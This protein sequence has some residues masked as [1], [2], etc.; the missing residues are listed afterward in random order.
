MVPQNRLDGV[1]SEQF[2]LKNS[3]NSVVLF[4]VLNY[5]VQTNSLLVTINISFHTFFYYRY[6]C[7]KIPRT[8]INAE[9]NCDSYELYIVILDSSFIFE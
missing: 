4:P 6:C 9:R 1:V 7:S 2:V 5:S 8:G 3:V